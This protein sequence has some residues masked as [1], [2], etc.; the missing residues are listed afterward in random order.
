MHMKKNYSIPAFF[1][2]TLPYLYF[3]GV[4]C[5]WLFDSLYASAYF[6]PVA[7]ILVALLVWQCKIQNNLVGFCTGLLLTIFTML[8]FMGVISEFRDFKVL[9]TSAR[10]LL[11]FGSTICTGGLIMAIVITINHLNNIPRVTN[12]IHDNPYCQ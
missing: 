2:N 5:Y 3:I 12:T 7:A 1:K 8:M 4:G 11:I 9:S 10:Q 6:N